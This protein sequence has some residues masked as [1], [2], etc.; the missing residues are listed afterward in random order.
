[1]SFINGENRVDFLILAASWGPLFG[2][3]S[4]DSNLPKTDGTELILAGLREL[5]AAVPG[6]RVVV[7]GQVPSVGVGG[8]PVPCAIAAVSPIHRRQCDILPARTAVNYQIRGRPLQE[9]LDSLS[10]VPNVSVV[11]PGSGLCD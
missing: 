6:K 5:L 2:V 9:A 11:N 4:Q 8:D 1:M 10:K 3:V 7:I